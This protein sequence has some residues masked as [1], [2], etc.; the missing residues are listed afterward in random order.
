MAEAAF[1]PVPDEAAPEPVA[2]GVPEELE[3][4]PEVPLQEY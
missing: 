2:V 4:E 3:P 1:L